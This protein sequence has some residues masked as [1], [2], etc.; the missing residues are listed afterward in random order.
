MTLTMHEMRL[1][2]AR[3]AL[4]LAESLVSDGQPGFIFWTYDHKSLW[5]AETEVEAE[6]REWG[7]LP[8]AILADGSV[9]VQQDSTGD[10]VDVG[11]I[12]HVTDHEVADIAS[13][14]GVRKN[15]RKKRSRSGAA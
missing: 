13:S 6:Y 9:G 10:A 3:K 14:V 15:R 12:P 1:Y 4:L 7:K 5:K 11:D 2:C 8:P